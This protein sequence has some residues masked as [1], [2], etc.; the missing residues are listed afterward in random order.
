M[1]PPPVP[2]PAARTSLQRPERLDITSVASPANELTKSSPRL[3]LKIYECKAG[4][5]EFV[6]KQPDNATKLSTTKKAA[7]DDINKTKSLTRQQDPPSPVTLRH[8]KPNENF[9]K[10]V[11]LKQPEPNGLWRRGGEDRASDRK[12]WGSMR[13]SPRRSDAGVEVESVRPSSIQSADISKTMLSTR[14]NFVNHCETFT[15]RED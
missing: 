15:S 3:S 1:Q 2:V 11:D 5:S 4:S 6:E 8:Q 14:Y 9:R 7:N 13:S 12:T 10:L